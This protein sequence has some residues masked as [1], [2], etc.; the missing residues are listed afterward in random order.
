M[1]IGLSADL[2]DRL[3]RSARTGVPDE[4]AWK[5]VN[6]WVQND[7][8]RLARYYFPYL[9]PFDVEEALQQVLVNLHSRLGRESLRLS[10]APVGYLVVMVKNACAQV[11][12]RL[13]RHRKLA[14][15]LGREVDFPSQ[16]PP[17]EPDL[18]RVEELRD[19][20]GR[21]SPDERRLLHQR[22]WLGL[23]IDQI[24]EEEGRTYSAVAVSLFR[25]RKQLRKMLGE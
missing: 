18:S 7:G 23:T 8:R 22:Y 4:S 25:L 9:A 5:E 17:S 12:R 13:Q 20:V 3:N 24:A 10:G 15:A 1:K 19:A 14:T 11:A 2:I 16:E 6:D 21:L